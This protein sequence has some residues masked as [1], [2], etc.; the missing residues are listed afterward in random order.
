[1]K[2]ASLHKPPPSTGSGCSGSD[3]NRH[4]ARPPAH[5]PARTLQLNPGSYLAFLLW[6]LLLVAVLPDHQLAL[7]LPLVV[8]FGWLSGRGALRVLA[9]RRFWLFILSTLAIAPFILGEADLRWGMLRISRA[10]LETGAWMAT[11]AA[12]LMLAFSASLGA[13]SVAQMMG[14]F[15]R[16]GLRGLGFAL[17]VA[18]NLGPVLRDTVEAAYHTLRLRGGFRRPIQTARLFLVTVI[19]NGVRYGD[20]VVQAASA[21]AFDPAARPSQGIRILGW[22]DKAFIGGLAA[23]AVGLMLAA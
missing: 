21:R 23:V 11:R 8:A 7:L 4:D 9:S 18:L 20:D 6:A 17:G 15:E 3:A 19:A 22:V 1:V 12:T 2:D 5:P 14:L 13:L 10:G 16:L